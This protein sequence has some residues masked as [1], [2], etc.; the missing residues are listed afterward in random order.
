[1]T[2]RANKRAELFANLIATRH[3][4]STQS[5]VCVTWL[6]LASRVKGRMKES[7]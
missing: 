3:L 1:L 5:S 4:Q 6:R 2:S 7:S